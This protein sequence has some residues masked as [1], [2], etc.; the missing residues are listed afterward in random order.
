[1][2]ESSVP[3]HDAIGGRNNLVEVDQA[4]LIFDLRDDFDVLPGLAQCVTDRLDIS[5]ILQRRNAHA[6]IAAMA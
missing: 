5:C 2:S 6:I 4:L 1:M 3:F